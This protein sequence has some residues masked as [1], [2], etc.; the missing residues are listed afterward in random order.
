MEKRVPL[1]SPSTRRALK[2]P[3]AAAIA[4]IAFSVLLGVSLF[5]IRIALPA[6][7]SEAGPW[8]SD[9]T[10]K[11]AVLF[12][13]A[14][15]PF[16]GIAFLWFIGVIRDR[17]GPQE[18]RFFATVFLGSGLLFISMLFVDIAITAGLLGAESVSSEIWQF[19][20]SVVA[21]LTAYALKMA[22]VFMI[23]TATISLR[24]AIM[25]RWLGWA[26]YGVAALLLFGSA[27]IPWIELLFPLWVFLVSVE[28]LR[29]SFRMN[30]AA[31][32]ADVAEAT[33]PQPTENHRA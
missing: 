33:L 9:P 18:D 29:A 26:G 31:P 14:L 19:G 2:T 8:L 20:H 6:T 27:L 5:I 32:V 30:A 10:R 23:S 1:V 12:A 15:V 24:T 4:G 28:V 16:A 11:N 7:P 25:S 3:R 21:L 13:L 17:M 22:A